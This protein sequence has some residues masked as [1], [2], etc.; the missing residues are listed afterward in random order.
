MHPIKNKFEVQAEKAKLIFELSV[1]KVLIKP[2]KKYK[3][4]EGNYISIVGNFLERSTKFVVRNRHLLPIVLLEIYF[5][6]QYKQ[7]RLV[8]FVIC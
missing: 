7:K 2:F 8:E 3:A 6:W 4:W 5:C 1:F